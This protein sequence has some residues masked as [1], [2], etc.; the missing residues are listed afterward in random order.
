[1]TA[2]PENLASLLNREHPAVITWEGTQRKLS[3]TWEQYS[4]CPHMYSQAKANV[5]T[6]TSQ[7]GEYRICREILERGQKR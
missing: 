4:K 2:I 1:M 6:E 3:K 7:I 5:P